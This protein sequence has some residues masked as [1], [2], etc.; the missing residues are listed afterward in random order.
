M[1]L[2][3]ERF[4]GTQERIPPAGLRSVS[5]AVEAILGAV[6]LDSGLEQVKD[7]RDALGLMPR[8]R[9]RT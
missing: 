1:D 9:L 6:Y 2:G 4:I 3:L 5:D 8:E 7:V